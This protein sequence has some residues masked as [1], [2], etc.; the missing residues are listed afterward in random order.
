MA[1]RE[2]NSLYRDRAILSRRNGNGSVKEAFY[3]GGKLSEKLL[4]VK[5]K[6]EGRRLKQ[7]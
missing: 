1:R 6:K 7:K 5:N 2:R 3:M 4:N